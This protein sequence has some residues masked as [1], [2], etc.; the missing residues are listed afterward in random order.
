MLNKKDVFVR[1]EK[2]EW[3]KERERGRDVSVIRNDWKNTKASM[4]K[5][6]REGEIIEYEI[7]KNMK[8]RMRDRERARDVFISNTT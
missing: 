1:K 8:E 3:K 7:E 6:E 2:R 5:K 4:N